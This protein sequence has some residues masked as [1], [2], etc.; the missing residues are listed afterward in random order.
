MS[1][2]TTMTDI[3]DDRATRLRR[4]NVIGA[5]L[6]GA[7]AVAVLA[8]SSDFALPVTATYLQGPPGPGV[9][10]ET[11]NL[12]DLPTGAAVAG[13]LLLSSLAHV[14]IATVLFPSY[15]QNLAVGRNPYRWVEYALSASLML[16]LIAQLTGIT[17]ATTLVGLFGVNASMI[18][19]GWLVEH[20]ETPGPDV[21]WIAFWFGCFAGIVPWAA[22]TLMI[23]SPGSAAEP[24]A[25][26]YG[27]FVSL[28][29]FFNI[30]A[31]NQ[32]LQYR[33]KG[34]WADYLFGERTYVVLS[35][36]AKSS[37]AWQVFGGTLAA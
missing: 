1:T 21:N 16:V 13:F 2:A 29:L 4:L 30:F 3:H 23:V 20:Y 34:R 33:A 24:P 12:F 19:F 35:L 8:L 37:L 22:I 26:V 25:F 36:T 10:T 31:A 18:L 11:V 9:P 17:E 27:I 15:R 7:Q 14:L 5:V 28:F 32:W 6:H